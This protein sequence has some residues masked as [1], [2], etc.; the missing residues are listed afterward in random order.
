[1]M[2]KIIII[3]LVMISIFLPRVGFGAFENWNYAGRPMALSGCYVALAND[4]SAILY[5]PAGIAQLE[6]PEIGASYSRPFLGLKNVNFDTGSLLLALP[7]FENF[8]FGLGATIFLED[9]FVY[10]YQENM[11]AINVA[12]G[13][14]E[15]FQEEGFN[16]AIG[17]NLKVLSLNAHAKNGFGN[18]DPVLE[19]K[20]TTKFSLDIGLL[21]AYKN[22]RLGISGQNLIPADFGVL[23]EER[24]PSEIHLGVGYNWKILG[25]KRVTPLVEFLYKGGESRIGFGTE[26]EISSI[27]AIQLGIDKDNYS[28]GISLGKISE[29]KEESADSGEFINLP[30]NESWAPRIDLS[31]VYARNVERQTGSPHIGL[32]W[33]F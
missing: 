4:V 17:S 26:C 29:I 8:T 25:K 5:N 3:V 33:R 31:Y 7:W 13:F 10:H 18:D 28:F 19:A 24:I 23:E 1:M 9:N 22:L 6:R 16:I 21:L 20:T 27:L 32:I 12:Y 30:L 14:Q 15:M 2:K 11:V